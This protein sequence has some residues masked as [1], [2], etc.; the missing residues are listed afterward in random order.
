MTPKQ[1]QQKKISQIC[2]FE[3]YHALKNWIVEHRER[4]HPNAA[5]TG[6]FAI[7]PEKVWKAK[8]PKYFEKLMTK[9]FIAM[10][11]AK[12]YNASKPPDAGKRID[13]RKTYNNVLNQKVTIGSVAYVKNNEV[14]PGMGDIEVWTGDEFNKKVHFYIEIK[15]PGDT[16][17]PVQ[18]EF[19][20]R[21]KKSGVGYH[22]IRTVDEFLL[23][24]ETVP[25][26]TQ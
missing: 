16:W 10:I 17:K 11:E 4:K 21:C 7:E 22:L 14:T 8:A 24:Y 26:W 9:I 6:Y 18:K 1:Y 20:E 25:V 19:A 13:Q 3:A 12:N 2:S 23:F 5:K 15:A